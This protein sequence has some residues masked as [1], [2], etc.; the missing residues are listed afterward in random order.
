MPKPSRISRMLWKSLRL[1][2]RPRRIAR[3]WR[4]KRR[5]IRKRLR[6]PLQR[7]KKRNPR[8]RQLPRN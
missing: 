8:R 1:T 6:K 4:K 7:R 2:A 5:R 3:H